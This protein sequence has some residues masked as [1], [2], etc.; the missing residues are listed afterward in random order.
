MIFFLFFYNTLQC[1][2]LTPP[3]IHTPYSCNKCRRHKP[4]K[5][6]PPWLPCFQS[7]N[8][9]VCQAGSILLSQCW[10]VSIQLYLSCIDTPS[11]NLQGCSSSRRLGGE[12]VN[13]RCMWVAR[14]MVCKT[15]S[16]PQSLTFRC[17]ISVVG[18]TEINLLHDIT[19]CFRRAHFTRHF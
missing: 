19:I 11:G 18:N 10:A 1:E 3:S 17:A 13:I 6:Y 9:I 16:Y 15:E 12:S 5:G 4:E 7:P 8:I 2:N 14:G